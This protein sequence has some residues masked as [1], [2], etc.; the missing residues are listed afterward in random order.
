M[1]MS[2]CSMFMTRKL[3]KATA[4]VSLCSDVDSQQYKGQYSS[5]GHQHFLQGSS[6]QQDQ[7]PTQHHIAS[8]VLLVR[9]LLGQ[10]ASQKMEAELSTLLNFIWRAA[11]AEEEGRGPCRKTQTKTPRRRRRRRRTL[12]KVYVT[13]TTTTSSTT[14]STSTN[15][16]ESSG[17]SMKVQQSSRTQP[18]SCMSYYSES[19]RK[20]KARVALLQVGDLKVK[21][22]FVAAAAASA[23]S[24]STYY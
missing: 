16:D 13:T 8:T 11:G 9:D 6:S 12:E 15:E 4:A 5:K 10:E 22:K 20:P 21:W 18:S 14:T 24:H 19:L 3:S 17:R 23:A 1:G 2:T 7:P